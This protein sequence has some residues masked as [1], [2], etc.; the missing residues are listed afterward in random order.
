[1]FMYV[2]CRVYCE[3]KV[4]TSV[5][6][7]IIKLFGLFTAGEANSHNNSVWMRHS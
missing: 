4:A 6:K 1:M 3:L 5:Y 2:L 7:I